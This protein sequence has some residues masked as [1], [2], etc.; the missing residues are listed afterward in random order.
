MNILLLQGAQTAPPA[1]GS[2]AAASIASAT[3]FQELLDQQIAKAPPERSEKPVREA[4]EQLSSSRSE[5]AQRSESTSQAAAEEQAA[6]SVQAKDDQTKPG[7]EAPPSEE[8]ATQA[9]ETALAGAGAVTAPIVP[10]DLVIDPAGEAAAAGTAGSAALTAAQ[11]AGQTEAAQTAPAPAQPGEAQPSAAQ[12]AATAA[13]PLVEEAALQAVAAPQ[14]TVEEMVQST[15]GKDQVADE[16]LNTTAVKVES[17]PADKVEAP[18]ATPA[19]ASASQTAAEPA[20]EGPSV[21]TAQQ[22]Q[23]AYAAQ[24]TQAAQEPARMAEARGSEVVKQVAPQLE[25]MAKSGTRTLTMQLN[26]AELGQ[27]DLRLTASGGTV[28]ITMHASQAATNDLLESQLNQL[29]QNL[30]NAG[31]QISD[32]NVGQQADKSAW[33]QPQQRGSGTGA[34]RQHE[35]PEAKPL[36]TRKASLQLSNIDYTV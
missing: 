12:P 27:I 15:A 33:Q 30:A 1:V 16:M 19:S 28:R 25:M 8:E 23:Q 6:G 20:D 26:P 18:A 9:E 36:P 5:P 31:V 7:D 13:A 4:K 11:L 21:T 2:N 32:L 14:P 35:Q 24:Q 10:Q 22:T 3:S 17:T 34:Y 29:R